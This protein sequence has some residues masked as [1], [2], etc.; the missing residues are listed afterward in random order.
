MSNLDMAATHLNASVGAVLSPLQLAAALQAA[1]LDVL[2][3]APEAAAAASYLFVEIEPRMIALC[4][5]ES[6]TDIAHANRLYHDLL[7]HSMPRVPRWEA[8][9]E[10]LL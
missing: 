6:G 8:A 4:A 9:V 7:A 1:S 2:S 5:Y 3:D 10:A